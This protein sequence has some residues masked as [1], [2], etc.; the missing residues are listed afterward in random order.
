[1]NSQQRQFPAGAGAATKRIPTVT[2]GSLGR[3]EQGLNL[4]FKPEAVKKASA[5]SSKARRLP[6]RSLVGIDLAKRP[7][8]SER[9]GAAGAKSRRRP[10]P[11]KVGL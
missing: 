1:M 10:P 7:G 9:G 5:A 4:P 3:D 6:P 2:P 11:S 8:A